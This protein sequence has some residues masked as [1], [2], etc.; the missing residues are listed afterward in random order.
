MTHLVDVRIDT[1]SMFSWARSIGI[2][3]A[4][5]GYLVHSLL[6]AAYG[7]Y[8]MQPF[9]H[10]EEG[11]TIRVLGYCC[12]PAE[13]LSSERRAVAEPAVSAAIRSELSKEMPA[14]WL[15]GARYSFTVRVS[16]IV[17]IARTR[18][19][20]DAFLRAPEGASR[21]DVYIDWLD[22][23]MANAVELLDA[24]LEAFSIETVSRRAATTNDGGKRPLGKRFSIPS[25]TVSGTLTIKDS[26]AFSALIARGVG[27]HVA[28][29]YGALMLRPSK[30]TR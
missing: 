14:D 29:G 25:A 19:Q 20:V 26:D 1:A 2:G 16:P 28:F 23:R 8:R 10:F 4:D 9:R 17:Q 22:K 6:C 12:V 3:S 11:A 27:R 13:H 5:V 21:D 24:K 30:P 18:K 7:E 15:P